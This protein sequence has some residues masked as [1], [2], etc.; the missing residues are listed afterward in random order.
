MGPKG[1]KDEGVEKTKSLKDKKLKRQKVEKMKSWKDKQLKRLK[2]KK[3]KLK[4]VR[5]V[6]QDIIQ[7]PRAL[8]VQQPKGPQI[9]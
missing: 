7:A 8:R 4:D 9:S 5:S 1:T 3:T 6:R 2:F